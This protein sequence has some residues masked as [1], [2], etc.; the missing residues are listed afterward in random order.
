[1]AEIRTAGDVESQFVVAQLVKQRNGM[2]G[3]LH[4]A[5][6]ADAFLE[7]EQGGTEA[8]VAREVVGQA[9]RL[10]PHVSSPMRCEGEPSHE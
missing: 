7:A 4:T 1:M 9:S 10:H 6:V 5:G 2:A 8:K 3:K